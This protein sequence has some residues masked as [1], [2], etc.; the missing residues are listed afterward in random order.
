MLFSAHCFL[1]SLSRASVANGL[2]KMSVV[3]LLCSRIV[4]GKN[5]LFKEVETTYVGIL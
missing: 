4:L 3:F 5:V 1:I 2:E